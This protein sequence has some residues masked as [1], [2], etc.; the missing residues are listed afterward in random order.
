MNVISLQIC[1]MFSFQNRDKQNKLVKEIHKI[2]SITKMQWPSLQNTEILTPFYHLLPAVS[3]CVMLK[4][5]DFTFEIYSIIDSVMV[6]TYLNVSL[7]LFEVDFCF[8]INAA[9]C[10]VF[11]FGMAFTIISPPRPREIMTSGTLF[12]N[13]SRFSKPSFW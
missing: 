3:R 2:C 7:C 10:S 9:K 13:S 4:W 11:L 6:L 12:K 1:K 8:E 5:R